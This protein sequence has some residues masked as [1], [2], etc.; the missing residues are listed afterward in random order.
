MVC[1]HFNIKKDLIQTASRKREIVQVRQVAMYLS[2]EYTDTSLSQ[3]GAII[4]KRNHATVL[5][6]CKMVKDQLEVDK[7]FRGEIS[8]ILKTLKV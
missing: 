5:H 6:A 8:K 2:K 1:C 7:E 4:G 3:I